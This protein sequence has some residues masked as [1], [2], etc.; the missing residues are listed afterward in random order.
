MA[1]RW[2]ACSR[3][4]LIPPVDTQTTLQRG[5]R[6]KEL[7]PPASGQRG[8]KGCPDLEG[9]QPAD[10]QSSFQVTVAPADGLPSE[11]PWPRTA[12]LSCFQTLDPQKLH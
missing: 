12:Q 4:Q 3:S 1:D 9:D 10:P 8:A 7:R 6:D 2:I 11:R 5:R